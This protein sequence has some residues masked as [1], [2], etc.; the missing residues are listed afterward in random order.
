MPKDEKL[1]YYFIERYKEDLEDFRES[2]KKLRKEEDIV[3][4]TNRINFLERKIKAFNKLLEIKNELNLE[5]SQSPYSWSTYL[6]KKGETIDWNKK[7]ENSYRLSDHWNFGYEKEHCRTEN[8]ED[9]GLAIA[10]FKN[11]VYHLVEKF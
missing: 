2:L 5:M 1:V 10:L 9:F 3:I 8:E 7:P 4:T 6:T 11:G